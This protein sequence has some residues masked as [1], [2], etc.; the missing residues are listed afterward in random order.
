M[1][2][3]PMTI[4]KSSRYSH[5]RSPLKPAGWQSLSALLST[6]QLA[7]AG[8]RISQEFQ[9]YGYRLTVDLNDLA[10]KSLYMKMAKTVDR[11]ILE[12]ARS[13][14]IDADS[15][16]SRA[17]LF[18]WKVKQLQQTTQHDKIRQS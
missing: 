17:R 11:S 3:Q 13:F 18:M 14:V 1:L 7:D 12:E 8:G 5:S 2:H 16:R 4:K 15:A 6:H 10:H 9:D